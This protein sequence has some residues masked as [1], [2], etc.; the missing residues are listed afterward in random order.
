MKPLVSCK[1]SQALDAATR[2]ALALSG[3]QLMEKASL[4]LWDAL[5]GLLEGAGETQEAF[6]DRFSE[7]LC[8]KLEGRCNDEKRLRVVAVCGKGD[9]GGDALAV[10]RHAYS[11]GY[12]N[13]S[14]LVSSMELSESCRRQLES[15]ESAGMAVVRWNPGAPPGACGIPDDADIILDGVLGTGMHGAARGEALAMIDC[16]NSARK[17]GRS[18]LVV[19]IDVPSG[20]SDDWQK[21]YP[22]VRADATLTIEPAKTAC[23]R[24]EARPACGELRIVADVFPEN[25][26]EK[27]GT[28]SLLCEADLPDLQRAQEL[29]SY[30]MSR[31]RVAVF[32]GSQGTLGAAMLCAKGA[33]AAGAGYVTLFVDQP[34]YP[35]IAPS[36][37]SVVVKTLGPGPD[38]FSKTAF[39]A[40]LIGPG[41]GQDEGRYSVLESLLE[42]GVPAVLDADAIRLA[43]RRTE[44]L[45]QSKS[46]LVLTPHPGEF[47]ELAK[48]LT[49]GS[50]DGS[51]DGSPEAAAFPLAYVSE[52]INAIVALKSH[53]TWIMA[54]SQRCSIWDGMTPELGTAGSGDVLAGLLAGI[55]ANKIAQMRKRGTV[56]YP[57]PDTMSN[58]MFEAAEAA[59]IAHGL[60]GRRL[61]R[62]AGWFEASDIVPECARILNASG[63]GARAR[64]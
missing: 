52:A 38:A 61:K 55:L 1:K 20:L 36:L 28:A 7:S 33:S 23:F 50:L 44:L 5:R 51:P 9:N 15:V 49:A 63:D 60:A 29:D 39:D 22:I 54:P 43:A 32:A 13:L 42:S 59:V 8:P 11:S 12:R 21:D 46:P 6:P 27:N 34:L 35:M 10:V 37:E 47:S 40:L 64:P 45:R 62:A 26:I 2:Q 31:G 48:A 58:V 57:N 30:K 18:P 56:E 4:R 25:L 3:I 16:I 17:G 24:P 41:W 14:A 53:V 19:S